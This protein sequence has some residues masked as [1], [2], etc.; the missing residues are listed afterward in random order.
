MN[1]IITIAVGVISLVSVVSCGGYN[2]D[3][4]SDYTNTPPTQEESQEGTFRA[5]LNPENPDIS[6]A[7]ATAEVSIQ[8]DEIKAQVF[9][10]NGEATTHAQH[11]HSG[12]RCP[13]ATD[14]ANA[15]GVIDANEAQAVYGPAVIP[16]DSDL[17]TDTGSFPSGANYSYDETGSF[18]QMLANFNLQGLNVEGKVIN[19]HGVPDSTELPATA[20]GGKA[21][22][23]VACGVLQKV[24]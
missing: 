19:I 14:D 22:F 24:D 3:D 17:S 15:D 23:P 8:G 11:I 12:A 10:G 20:Q 2:D 13:T 18:S 5:I 1:R 7:A 21:A 16:L 9:F 4:D 6:S